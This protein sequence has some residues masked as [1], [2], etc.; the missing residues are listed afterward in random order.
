M[1]LLDKILFY[2]SAKSYERSRRSGG[3]R[4]SCDKLV[5][6]GPYRF[7]ENAKSYLFAVSKSTTARI[8]ELFFFGPKLIYIR[9]SEEPAA[10]LEPVNRKDFW[11]GSFCIEKGYCSSAVPRQPSA[12]PDQNF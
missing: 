8:S 9:T 7:S 2:G 12:I 6:F 10:G 11:A 3:L 5:A 1:H 4:L